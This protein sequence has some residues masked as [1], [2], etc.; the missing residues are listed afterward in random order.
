[1]SA[2]SA[3]VTSAR[4][5]SLRCP[6]GQFVFV[7]YVRRI[8]FVAGAHPYTVLW[9]RGDAVGQLDASSPGLHCPAELWTRTI[10]VAGLVHV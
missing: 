1:M 2:V 4:Q 3:L 10:C 9:P 6:R 8:P 5:V 7:A